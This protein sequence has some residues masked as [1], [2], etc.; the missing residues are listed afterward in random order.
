MTTAPA[1]TLDKRHRCP[2][3]ISSHCVGRSFRCSLSSRD[4]QELMAERGGIV[5]HAAVRYWGRKFGQGSAKQLRRRRPQ[6][7]AKGH[8]DEAFLPINGA[9]YSLG[10][11]VDQDD[12]VLDILGPSRRNQPAAK[13]CCK[14]LRKGLPYVPR[15]RITDT[16]QSDAAAK[17]EVLPGGGASAEP[18]PQ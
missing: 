17:R 2:A 15:V 16:L 14:K 9:R 5:S 4:V 18:L 10:R 3:A 1:T 8:L 11:A 6:P 13:Q 7:G 12:T